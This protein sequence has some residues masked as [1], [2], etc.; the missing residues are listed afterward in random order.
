VGSIGIL[1]E[2]PAF[3]R[4]N[5]VRVCVADQEVAAYIPPCRIFP[6]SFDLIDELLARGKG[7]RYRCQLAQGAALF[8]PVGGSE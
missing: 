3:V 5:D 8:R 6:E 1:E 2:L 4:F 7:G